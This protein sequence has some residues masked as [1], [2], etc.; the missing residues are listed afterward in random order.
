[1][2][3][4]NAAFENVSLEARC[5]VLLLLRDSS[6]YA[7]LEWT[8][9]IF[10]S[11]QTSGASLSRVPMRHILYQ[12]IYTVRA[13]RAH[14]RLSVFFNFGHPKARTWKKKTERISGSGDWS[15]WFQRN[16]SEANNFKAH[17]LYQITRCWQGLRIRVSRKISNFFVSCSRKKI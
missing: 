8:F 11:M 5:D 12:S 1:M 6:I 15:V 9:F 10:L 16:K 3:E 7:I 13:V 4:R 2:C 17:S 14:L